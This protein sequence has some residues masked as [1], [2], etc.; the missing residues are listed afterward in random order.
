MRAKM[1]P[2]TFWLAPNKTYFLI[3]GLSANKH[4]ISWQKEA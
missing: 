3:A 2:T 1:G 4:E